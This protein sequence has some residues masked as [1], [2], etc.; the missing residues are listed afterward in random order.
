MSDE[1][2]PAMIDWQIRASAVTWGCKRA[3]IK[4]NVTKSQVWTVGSDQSYGPVL[5]SWATIRDI[6]TVQ[7]TISP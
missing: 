3:R 2:Q 6:I 1:R 5:G 4:E 7:Q